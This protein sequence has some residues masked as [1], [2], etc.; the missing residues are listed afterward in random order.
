MK[1]RFDSTVVAHAGWE[2]FIMRAAFAAI[3]WLGIPG[4]LP[5]P[6]QPTPNGLAALVDLTP[7]AD[8]THLGAL[9]GILAVAL[10]FYVIAVGTLPALTVITLALVAAGSLENSQGA[11]NHT[12]QPVAL[13]ALAQWLVSVW[14]A[15]QNRSVFAAFDATT[16]QRLVIHAAKVAIV[17]C[18]LTSVAT[19]I[20]KSGLDWITK[21]PNLA[22]SI[23]KSNAKYSLNTFASPGPLAEAAPE[24]IVAH[25]NAARV[26][27]SAGLLVELLAF[28]ALMGRLPALVIG[29]ALI[30]M[31]A[32][33]AELMHLH[34]RT[35]QQL[36]L[37]FLVNVPFAAWWCVRALLRQL[38]RS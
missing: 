24:W 8:P 2:M 26:F 18:Y 16:T 36:S 23:V 15:I 22:V 28:L 7:L 35:F 9:R 4:W 27:F 3:V 14:F 11:I 29:T 33:V 21:T 25:P 32:F 37:I 31:H 13:T 10:V 5:Y 17:A 19:K 20:E 1:F 34:F 30:A 38:K 12:F 6:E